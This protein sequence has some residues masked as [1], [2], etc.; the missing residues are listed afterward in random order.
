MARTKVVHLNRDGAAALDRARKL[1]KESTPGSPTIARTQVVA[2]ALELFCE[3]LDPEHDSVV[4][5]KKRMAEILGV[6]TF[7]LTCDSLAKV[8]KHCDAVADDFEI[9]ACPEEQTI[10]VRLCG[11]KIILSPPTEGASPAPGILQ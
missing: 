11:K 2:A 6:K 7:E 8:L 10:I 9:A 1:L 5:S 4:F 3:V